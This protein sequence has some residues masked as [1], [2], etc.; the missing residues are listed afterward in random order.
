VYIDLSN[1][2]IPTAQ[3]IMRDS[4]TGPVETGTEGTGTGIRAQPAGTGQDDS[5]PRAHSL[6]SSPS[7]LDELRRRRKSQQRTDYWKT[8]L[9]YGSQALLLLYLGIV[10]YVHVHNSPRPGLPTV[11]QAIADLVPEEALCIAPAGKALIGAYGG[12]VYRHSEYEDD[13]AGAF[14]A[15]PIDDAIDSLEVSPFNVF[16]DTFDRGARSLFLQGLFQLYGFNR[17]EARRNFHEC[18]SVDPMCVSCLWGL[19]STWGPNLNARMSELEAMAGAA[20]VC[21]ARRVLTSVQERDVSS[22]GDQSKRYVSLFV[23]SSFGLVLD[24][25][26]DSLAI[27]FGSRDCGAVGVGAT[28]YDEYRLNYC[29]YQA[30]ERLSSRFPDNHDIA[31]LYV[32]AM[33]QLTPWDYFDAVKEKSEREHV[34]NSLHQ[35]DARAAVII[36]NPPLKQLLRPPFQLLTEVLRIAP[37][38]PLALH[39][40]IHITEQSSD[41][42]VGHAAA[43]RLMYISA[44][45]GSNHLNHMPAHIYIRIGRFHDAIEA[46]RRAIDS[47]KIYNAHC[48]SPYVPLHDVGLLVMT[49]LQAGNCRL[50]L[51]NAEASA[52]GTTATAPFA[53]DDVSSG[54]S[55]AANR[56]P[57]NIYASKYVTALFPTPRDLVFCRFGRWRKLIAMHAD[58]PFPAMLRVPTKLTEVPNDSLRELDE[59][60]IGPDDVALMLNE[61]PLYFCVVHFYSQLLALTH[62]SSKESLVSDGMNARLS[63]LSHFTSLMLLAPAL[64]EVEHVFYPYHREMAIMMNL[65]VNAAV[66][67]KLGERLQS[68]AM[69]RSAMSIQDTFSYMEPENF[70]LP[71]RQC[72]S[73]TLLQSAKI[74]I[75]AP[76]FDGNYSENLMEAAALL[77]EATGLYVEDLS[78]GNH[79]ENGWSLQGLLRSLLLHRQLYRMSSVPGGF[80]ISDDLLTNVHKL[81]GLGS[82]NRNDSRDMLAIKLNSTGSR[83]LM[84]DALIGSVRSKFKASWTYADTRIRGS[85]CELGLC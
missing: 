15:S 83:L 69:L 12:K 24:G 19:A 30:L 39:L 14:G 70:Y 17:E 53:A 49:A 75:E 55:A 25:L 73:A 32:E 67:W 41:P 22:P 71:V 5:D 37:Y 1:P 72:L 20:A 74:R 34:D 82:E 35:L 36:I 43:D 7:S 59:H 9:F 28:D 38:H 26:I 77:A 48:L 4:T 3:H 76:S 31:V 2:H 27:R 46:S 56:P 21:E 60:F 40:F 44:F 52:L 79:P 10:Y 64:F 66:K 63:Y 6:Q 29:Y 23:N 13:R 47:H 84:L 58:S 33:L 62:T 68:T 61:F 57:M 16:V 8:A 80:A 42:R 78:L 45:T 81:V 11:Q 50:A 85:C 54:G 51:Q 18:H 65:T